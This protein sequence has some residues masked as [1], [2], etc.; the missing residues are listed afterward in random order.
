M[1]ALRRGRMRAALLV[2]IGLISAGIFALLYAT[3]TMRS[4][5]LDTVDKRFSIRGSQGAPKDLI[6][7]K[8]DDVTFEQLGLRWPFRRTVHADLIDRIV[9][10]R[11]KAIVYDVQFTENSANPNDDV[12]LAE[13]INGADG[14]VVLATT[15]V[16]ARGRTRI[17]NGDAVLRAIGAHPGNGLLPLDPGG[18]LRRTAY[19]IS[20][21]RT[22]GVVGASV[23][24]RKPVKKFPG[25]PWIDYRGPPGT[26]TSVSFSRVLR[27]QVPKGLFRDK[28]VVVG[29]SAP[30]LQD[31]HPT[32]TSGS[33][34]MSGAEIQAN[35]LDTV[36]RGLPLLSSASWVDYALIA[37]MALAAPLL[38]LVLRPLRAIALALVIGA[39]FAVAVQI[40]FDNG[41]VVAFV[42][43]IGALLLSSAAVLAVYYLTT[44]LERERV[45]DL[46]SRF[47]PEN[48]VD[49]VLA[50]T[51]D[52]LRLGGVQLEG[53]VMFC[54]LRG[55]TTY[56]ETQPPDEVIAALNVYLSEMSEAIL[57]HGGTLVS[58]M[59]DGIMAV[60][61]APLAQ[62]DHADRALATAREML[63][64]RLPR[65]NAWLAEHA[66]GGPF[67]MGIGLNSG[68]FMSGNVGS[69]RRLEYTA[70]GD[71]TN[72]AAR[73][74]GM[75]KGTPHQL[76]VTESVRERLANQ[77]GGLVFVDEMDVRGRAAR[78]RLWALESEEAQETR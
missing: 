40:A 49:D 12:A 3:D 45:R 6:V 34:E 20:G 70:I 36:R 39:L 15:E 46:F 78:V 17:L 32:S 50:N 42:Y 43:P 38:S 29:P 73:I 69:E 13:S 41:R 51:D 23:A 9:A 30:S 74:E 18:V 2:G 60:F 61:G 16:D 47:V 65:F 1:R 28:I 31:I 24:E 7:V 8:I 71:T 58:Y 53:T 54:D 48:V 21:L 19:E 57:D 75:T 77:D 27:K 10:D 76:L 56:S 52:E 33:D 11:P 68:P 26:I 35:A 25:T 22:I 62:E 37:L 4:L 66:R 55:F 64:V 63:T 44:A 72:T 5:E 14:K 59:G 67:R